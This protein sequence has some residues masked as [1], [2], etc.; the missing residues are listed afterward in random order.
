M[1]QY[2]QIHKKHTKF[3]QIR[4]E[5]INLNAVKITYKCKK[6]FKINEKYLLSN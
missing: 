3:V 2:C 6:C 5:R 1:K 4:Y